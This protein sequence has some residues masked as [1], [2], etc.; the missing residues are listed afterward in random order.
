MAGIILGILKIVQTIFCAGSKDHED[1]QQQQHQ[2]QGSYAQHAGNNQYPLQS[3]PGY[4]GA[5]HQQGHHQQQQQH[6]PQGHGQGAWGGAGQG[7]GHHAN[8]QQ[9][10]ASGKPHYQYEGKHTGGMIGSQPHGQYQ[11]GKSFGGA[12]VEYSTPGWIDLLRFLF[13]VPSVPIILS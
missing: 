6:R 7:Q 8:Q 12:A 3:Q 10:H 11:V 13:I 9:S 4:P 2:Q 1:Q 5:H